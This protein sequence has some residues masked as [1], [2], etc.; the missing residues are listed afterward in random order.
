[1]ALLMATAPACLAQGKAKA[2]PDASAPQA[3][4]A[5]Q[6]Q[7][8]PAGQPTS[9]AG[10][11]VQYARSAGVQNCLGRI[12]QVTG[13]LTAGTSNVGGFFIIPPAAP[14]TSLLTLSMEIPQPANQSAYASASFAPNQANG[15]GAVY[16]TVVYWPQNPEAVAASVYPNLKRVGVLAKQ[17][18]VLE[19]GP[20]LRIFLMP[21]GT[22]CV[23]IKKELV[24]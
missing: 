24:R 16:E 3:Q 10:A 13:F 1:M 18:T 7:K 22:G 23:A 11:F 19:G 20:T 8:A 4:P 6:G 12:E 21:A 15:S 2:K 17:I 14:N 9:A 5:A